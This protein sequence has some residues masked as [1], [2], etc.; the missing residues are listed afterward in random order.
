MH[1]RGG[2]HAFGR[3]TPKCFSLGEIGCVSLPGEEGGIVGMFQGRGERE[4][5]DVKVVMMMMVMMMMMMSRMTGTI[6]T[7]SGRYSSM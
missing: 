6:G 5:R 1:C 7:Y 3:E 2:A 4:G